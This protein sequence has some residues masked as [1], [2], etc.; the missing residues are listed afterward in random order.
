MHF[1]DVNAARQ[2]Y[3]AYAHHVGFSVR[4]GQHKSTDGV[5]SHKRYLC[6]KEG[7]REEKTGNASS[8]SSTKKNRERK[9]TRCG[10][11]AKLV[12]KRTQED[13]YVVS[14]FEKGHNHMLVTPS[15]QQF[16]RSNRKI[17]S[18]A[19]STLFN[20]QR[21]CIGTSAAYRFLRVGLGGFD[22]VGCMKRDL[23]NFH[24]SLRCHIK[25]SDAQMFVDQL[26][27]KNLANPGFYFDYV[28]DDKGRLLH[29]FW[30]DATCRQNYKHF[31][32]LVSFDST[33]ST[34]EYNM[35]F[36]PFTGVNHHKGSIFFGAAFLHD[37]K[38]ESFVWLFRTFLKA[39][40][41]AEPSLMITDECASMIS[42]LGTVFPTTKHRL[43]M[44]HI[45]NKVGEKVSPYLKTNEDFHDRLGLVVWASETPSEFEERWFKV[46][47]EFGLEEN[48]WFVKRFELR[49]SWV[50]AS[51]TY[52]CQD[53]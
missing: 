25:S 24:R 9:I 40:G 16:M 3:E 27:R 36:A 8:E 21:A 32:N 14:V 35:I 2:F 47:S 34:N 11:G 38:T 12:I 23:Q 19:K 29:V 13:N 43:C 1:A 46:M 53:C 52:L 49:E 31:G 41:G 17:N 20:C 7:F 6:A 48:E 10:C 42:A 50:P 37:E 30:A 28:I 39:M 15:K 51:M 18:K 26:G 33:Y 45:M 44:W 5:I 4:V 22:E